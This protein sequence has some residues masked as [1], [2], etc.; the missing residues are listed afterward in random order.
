MFSHALSASLF[1]KTY[2]TLL[3]LSKFN[4]GH[5]L[6]EAFLDFLLQIE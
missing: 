1:L 5:L 3:Y 4:C 2:L 6:Q